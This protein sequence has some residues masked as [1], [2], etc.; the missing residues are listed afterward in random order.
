MV[1]FV[2]SSQSFD[3]SGVAPLCLQFQQ[4]PEIFLCEGMEDPDSTGELCV[5]WTLFKEIPLLRLLKK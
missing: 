2:V 1:F 3:I 5:A 4:E